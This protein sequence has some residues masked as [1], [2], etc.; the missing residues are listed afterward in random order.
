M[1]KVNT[2]DEIN[3]FAVVNTRDLAALEKQIFDLN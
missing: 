2:T 1:R 3:A